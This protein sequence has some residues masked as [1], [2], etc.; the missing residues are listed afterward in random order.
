MAQDASVE[1]AWFRLLQNKDDSIETT[2]CYKLFELRI[3]DEMLFQELCA[4]MEN[5]LQYFPIEIDRLKTLVW[6]ISCT[7]RSVF[8]HYDKTDLFTIENFDNNI[9]ARWGADYCDRFRYLL[10]LTFSILIAKCSD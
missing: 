2:F 5:V 9:A 8:S 1:E 6:I 7:F 3:F 10:D 4:D